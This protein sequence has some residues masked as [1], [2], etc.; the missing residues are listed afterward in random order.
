MGSR[1]DGDA[2]AYSC[3]AVDFQWVGHGPVAAD[4][5]Y[6]MWTSLEEDLVTR[7]VSPFGWWFT[8]W[9]T[10]LERLR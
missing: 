1:T 4:L 7:K 8:G 5:V 6:L 10:V 9:G 2:A 3:A